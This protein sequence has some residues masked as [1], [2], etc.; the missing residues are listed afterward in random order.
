MFIVLVNYCLLHL[1]RQ[2]QERQKPGR[3][4]SLHVTHGARFHFKICQAG[5]LA[6]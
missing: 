2:S 3:S 5:G 1:F 4:L 6:N